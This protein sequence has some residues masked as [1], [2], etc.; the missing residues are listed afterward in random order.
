MNVKCLRKCY[1]NIEII[2][3][4]MANGPF[5]I[6]VTTSEKLA[7]EQTMPADAKFYNVLICQLRQLRANRLESLF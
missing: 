3:T 7:Q 6:P 4:K 5:Q 2:L 1:V